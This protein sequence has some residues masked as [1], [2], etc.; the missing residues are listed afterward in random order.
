MRVIYYRL[1][2]NVIGCLWSIRSK[3]ITTKER[4]DSECFFKE[5]RGKLFFVLGTGRSGTQLLTSLL[6]RSD[7][8][9][10]F[11]E[12]NFSED[13]FTMDLFRHEPKEAIAY[14]NDFRKNQ[15]YKRLCQSSADIY[16]EANGT[17]RYH[18]AAIKAVFPDVA[19]FLVY[20]DGRGFVRSVMGWPQFY[21]PNSRGAYALAPLP[22]D[23]YFDEWNSMSRFEKI[24][25]SWMESNSAIMREVK[26]DNWLEFEKIVTDYEYF[27]E[28]LAQKVNL[29]ISYDE[30]IK[31]VSYKSENATR[32]HTFP[33][34]DD[35]SND[36]KGHFRRICGDTMAKLGYDF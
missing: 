20:R 22:E 5:K 16:G 17:I 34:W 12:P 28:Y 15:V 11:H 13:V 21:G 7:Q 30:W 6:N 9:V 31:V 35:W 23:A 18:G 2:G 27:S 10:V 36:Q 26:K 3:L 1:R 25:W 32:E 14:W 29:D 33:V 4:L 19:L 24:C 8:S